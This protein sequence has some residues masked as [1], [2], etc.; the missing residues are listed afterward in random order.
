RKARL[1]NELGARGNVDRRGEVDAPEHD[2]AIGRRGP[3]RYPNLLP[4]VQADAGGRDQRLKSALS[5]HRWGV[6]DSSKDT[7]LISPPACAEMP[8]CRTCRRRFAA[9]PP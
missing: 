3:Q 8:G 1:A 5:Q 4:G 2:A 7:R 9:R 6:A